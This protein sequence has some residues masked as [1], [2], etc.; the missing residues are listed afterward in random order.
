MVAGRD[1]GADRLGQ[2]FERLEKLDS[3]L[4][5][6]ELVDKRLEMRVDEV[7]LS[8]TKLRLLI[9]S[10]SANLDAVLTEIMLEINR[11][12]VV[13]TNQTGAIAFAAESI[14][15]IGPD[16]ADS[17]LPYGTLLLNIGS[18]YN[19]RTYTF[20]SPNKGLY[21]FS[22]TTVTAVHRSCSY[23]AL[24][25]EAVDGYKS[26][27]SGEAANSAN[28]QALLE[29]APGDQV[30]VRLGNSNECQ[31]IFHDANIILRSSSIKGFLIR[32]L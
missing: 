4:T 15:S 2:I 25:G 7:E 32:K 31:A 13:F 22:W 18:H 19:G 27:G 5:E 10:Y 26:Y 16:E 9:G 8:N 3:R 21:Y 30:Q 14:T 23:I 1:S 24:N 17:V 12:K 20:T 11:L 29:L 28:Q 6:S